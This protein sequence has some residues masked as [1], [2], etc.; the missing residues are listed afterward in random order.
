MRSEET[1]ELLARTKPKQQERDY[2][3]LGFALASLRTKNSCTRRSKPDRPA[4]RQC[5]L[6]PLRSGVRFKGAQHS[7]QRIHELPQCGRLDKGLR[8]RRAVQT[9]RWQF[10]L[11]R[12]GL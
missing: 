2:S 6:P 8:A 9:G 7:L 3:T 10:C 4:R 12:L 5:S 1:Y 11:A